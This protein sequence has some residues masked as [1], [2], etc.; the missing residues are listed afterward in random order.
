[1]RL[2]RRYRFS[3]SHRLHRESFTDEQ[4]RAVYGKCNNPYGHGHDYAIEIGVEG[5]VDG[6]TGRVIALADLDALVRRE[7][8]AR[9]DQSDLNTLPDFAAA[10]PTTENLA[11]AIERRLAEKWPASWP[12]LDRIRIEETRRNKFEL[13][14]Q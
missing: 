3:A 8:V 2:T 1:M 5:P 11:A 12:R 9:F 7:V 6:T 10:P 13:R 4:N 14:H